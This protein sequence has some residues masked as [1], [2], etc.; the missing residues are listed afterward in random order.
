VEFLNRESFIES[1]ET[2]DTSQLARLLSWR[3]SQGIAETRSCGSS[4]AVKVIINTGPC[5]PR[6]SSQRISGLFEGYNPAW[7][8]CANRSRPLRSP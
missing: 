4:R 1:F 5:V 7:R 2:I 8:A 3:R 6:R